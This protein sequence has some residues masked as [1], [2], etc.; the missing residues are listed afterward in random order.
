MLSNGTHGYLAFLL[1]TPEEK[2][3]LEDMPFIRKY[4]NVFPDELVSLPPER[5]I[6]FKIDLA[7]G[8]T[9]I[10]KI[11]YQMAPAE[12]KELKL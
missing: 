6:E 4:S 5:E 8:T 7:P 12:I 1:N 11:P 3:K 9:P 10:L 2:V